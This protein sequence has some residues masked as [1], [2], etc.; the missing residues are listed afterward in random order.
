MDLS[1]F[2]WLYFLTHE[3]WQRPE[4]ITPSNTKYK[5]LCTK[6]SIWT[7]LLQHNNISTRTE[8]SLIGEFLLFSIR[9]WFPKISRGGLLGL[10]PHLNCQDQ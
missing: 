9:K 3:K 6:L 10:L 1:H 2:F 4:H 8:S 7:E 5:H